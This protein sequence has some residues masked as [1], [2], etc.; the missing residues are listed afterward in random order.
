MSGIWERIKADA[1]DRISSHLL[2]AAMVVRNDNSFTGAQILAALNR[3]IMT[4]LT[5]SE[6]TD[7]NNIMTQLVGVGSVTNRLVYKEKVKAALIIAECG[8]FT[9]V[10]FRSYLG[11]A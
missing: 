1:V 5:A 6:T 10:Q 8:E 2:D 4:P 7:L 9:E 11:I 3:Q